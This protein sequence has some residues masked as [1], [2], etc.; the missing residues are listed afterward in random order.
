MSCWKP[1]SSPG[2]HVRQPQTSKLQTYMQARKDREA[3]AHD[4]ALFLK[5]SSFSLTEP[6][7]SPSHTSSHVRTDMS[8]RVQDRKKGKSC[9][10][11]STSGGGRGHPWNQ[12]KNEHVGPMSRP[13]F[14]S[15]PTFRG[16]SRFRFL[17]PLPDSGQ[18]LQL[19]G[20]HCGSRGPC[21]DENACRWAAALHL[22]PQQYQY[23]IP[24]WKHNLLRGSHHV[25]SN[26]SQTPVNFV[27][28]RM[29][30][31]WGLGGPLKNNRTRESTI[32]ACCRYAA[33]WRVDASNPC[34]V[35]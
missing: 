13:V 23:P 7:M 18:R 1:I 29:S 2:A 26:P 14:S 24:V 22:H 4:P 31:L 19:R 16:P 15:Q 6:Q 3:E 12:K 11:L 32:G 28:S 35:R 27:S 17:L 8:L 25:W 5:V 33:E 30:R 20:K 34:Q 10:T 21:L 9:T